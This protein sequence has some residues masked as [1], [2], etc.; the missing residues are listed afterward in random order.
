MHEKANLELKKSA[1]EAIVAGK[2]KS[3]FLAQMSHEIRTPLNAVLALI[4]CQ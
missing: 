3:Q 4:K 2:A 1:N